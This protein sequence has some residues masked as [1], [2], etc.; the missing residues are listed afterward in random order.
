M[1][2]TFS[3]FKI[4]LA[5]GYLDA[6][7]TAIISP[8][9]SSFPIPILDVTVVITNFG[10]VPITSVPVVIDINGPGAPSTF[11]YNGLLA[12]ST[13]DTFYVTSIPFSFFLNSLCAYTVGDT[14]PANDTT[15]IYC[16]NPM[17]LDSD[18]NDFNLIVAPNPSPGRFSI[19]MNEMLINNA[20]IEISDHLG[21][22]V[23]TSDF[24]KPELHIDFSDK[25]NGLYFIRIN[26]SSTV[27]TSKLIICN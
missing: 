21:K 11:N 19:L 16:G 2:S 8:T 3:F 27:V 13:S 26:T 15:C 25:S 12:P 4:S 1:L 14:I 24:T 18:L 20:K 5:Q 9:C 10:T 17:S 7:I 6:G 23:W 22:S